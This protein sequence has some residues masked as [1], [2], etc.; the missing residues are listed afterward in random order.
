MKRARAIAFAAFLVLLAALLVPR[1]P[2]WAEEQGGEKEG[3]P[4]VSRLL[5]FG[6][7]ALG[8]DWALERE[9]PRRRG[10]VRRGLDWLAA[11]QAKSGSWEV[12]EGKTFYGAGVTGL[13]LSAFLS[14][15]ATGKDASPYADAVA[16]G[17]AWLVSVQDREGCVGPRSSQHFIYNHAYATLA[18]V[19]AYGLT[20]DERW[21]KAAQRG[22]DF[23]FFARNPGAAWRYG[24]KPGDNDVSVTGSMMLAICAAYDLNRAAQAA[25][26]VPP[27]RIDETVFE[28]VRSFLE[29]MTDPTYGRTGYITRGGQPARP[30][31]LIDRFPSD[32]SESLTAVGIHMRLTMPG[33]DE[34]HDRKMIALGT[35]LLLRQLPRWDPEAGRDLYY[36]HHGSLAMARLGGEAGARWDQAVVDALVPAQVQDGKVTDHLGS[37]DPV[38]VWAP[39]GGRVY[40][41]AMAVLCLQAGQRFPTEDALDA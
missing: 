11:H 22:L 41:T 17:L 38:T 4:D 28:G 29:S 10:A 5:P 16:R 30:L 40:T 35:K 6:L 32:F 25:D 7:R 12:V 14:A 34:A 23:S 21:K 18:L 2:A 13:A 8:P 20:G 37:W 1:P 36:W 33:G 24:A 31:E 19:E 26:L 15:G 39:D 3:T 9:A 27:F